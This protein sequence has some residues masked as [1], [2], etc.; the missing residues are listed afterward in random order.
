MIHKFLTN[1]WPLLFARK[2]ELGFSSL[3]KFEYSPA[4]K[5]AISLTIDPVFIFCLTV[6]RMRHYTFFS[7]VELPTAVL[8]LASIPKPVFLLLEFEGLSE[9]I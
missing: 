6:L 1:S 4:L 2:I 3:N 9:G 8:V 5:R 7:P